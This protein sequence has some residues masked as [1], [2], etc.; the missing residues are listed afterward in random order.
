MYIPREQG[1]Y[2]RLLHTA[3]PMGTSRLVNIMTMIKLF[4]AGGAAGGV[5][6]LGIEG[7]PLPREYVDMQGLDQ[8]LLNESA[9]KVRGRKCSRVSSR[10]TTQ[11]PLWMLLENN[12]EPACTCAGAA[13]MRPV[14]KIKPEPC[15]AYE[16][17]INR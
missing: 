1:N 2:N 14:G 7:T 9:L 16:I 6:L 17:L 12:K 3:P 10:I 8:K 11:I 5:D 13:L 15:E 4:F